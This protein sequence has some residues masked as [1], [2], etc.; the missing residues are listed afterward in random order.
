MSDLYTYKIGIMVNFPVRGSDE[1]YNRII[2]SN[3]SQV[4]CEVISQRALHWLN[5][6]LTH[7]YQ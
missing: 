6:R 1:E 4:N 7:N 5:Y 3:L 2:Y